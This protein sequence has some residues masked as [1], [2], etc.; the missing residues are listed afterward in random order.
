MFFFLGTKKK[1]VLRRQGDRAETQ[2]RNSGDHLLWVSRSQGRILIPALPWFCSLHCLLK[3]MYDKDPRTQSFFLNTKAFSDYP[4]I[5][6][7]QT[8]F[9]VQTTADPCHDSMHQVHPGG[10]TAAEITDWTCTHQCV[11][12]LQAQ[13]LSSCVCT[14]WGASSVQ[15]YWNTLVSVLS[16]KKKRKI[17]E[18]GLSWMSLKDK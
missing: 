5:P 4:Q 8:P 11:C 7:A 15:S 10:W 6:P 17:I 1:N 3:S 18:L 2:L 14:V 12:G 13:S 16:S 9:T